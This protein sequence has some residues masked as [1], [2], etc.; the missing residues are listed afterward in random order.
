MGSFVPAQILYDAF[1]GRYHN[2]TGAIVLLCVIWGSFF[3]GGLSITTSAARVVSYISSSYKVP[4]KFKLVI[5]IEHQIWEA[6]LSGQKLNVKECFSSF[7]FLVQVK[8]NKKDLFLKTS[9]LSEQI[10]SWPQSLRCLQ[11]MLIK[12]VACCRYM[13]YHEMGE[14]LSQKFGVK[15][16]Q[17][18]RSQP[19]LSGSVL[20]L[21][22]FWGFPSLRSAWSLL[23]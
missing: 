1:H 13:L 15:F 3:F 9:V 14:L 12:F 16:I 21:Q 18:T 2:A 19:M 5:C 4:V 6:K 8:K 23:P 17:S 10:N 7:S 22:S 20:L 11:N